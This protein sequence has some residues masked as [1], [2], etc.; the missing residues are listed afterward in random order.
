M[1][2]NALFL[3]RVRKFFHGRP[4]FEYTQFSSNLVLVSSVAVNHFTGPKGFTKDF[5]RP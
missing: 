3:E 4:V 1:I 5:L 2:M